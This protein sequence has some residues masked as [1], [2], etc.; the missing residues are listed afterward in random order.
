[1]I[2]PKGKL[3]GGYRMDLTLMSQTNILEYTET[4]AGWMRYGGAIGETDQL[5]RCSIA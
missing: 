3:K 5:R 1:V 2:L 4:V